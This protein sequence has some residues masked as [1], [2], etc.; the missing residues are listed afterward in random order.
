M[1]CKPLLP[2]TLLAG[3][4]AGC[5]SLSPESFGFGGNREEGDP[6]SVEVGTEDPPSELERIGRY[7]GNVP[8]QCATRAERGRVLESALN[9]MRTRAARAG[10]T[11][12][13]VLG[14]GPLE[15]RGECFDGF[16]R[17]TGVAYGPEDAAEETARD[18][19][20]DRSADEGSDRD[21]ARDS[22][23]EQDT[24][25]DADAIRSAPDASRDSLTSRL[26]EIE[27]LRERRLLSQEEYEQ[28]RDRVLDAAYD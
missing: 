8:S 10:A 21:E 11:Y 3:L 19:S 16:F 20:R 2:I 5:S 18:E 1:A 6:E 4:L 9:K 7:Q 28:L 14:T 24:R 13:R 22:G 17:I 25:R 27:T 12:M 23:G 26:E 15:E